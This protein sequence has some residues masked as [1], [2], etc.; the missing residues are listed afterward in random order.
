MDQIV[1]AVVDSTDEII[2]PRKISIHNLSEFWADYISFSLVSLFHVIDPYASQSVNFFSA[3]ERSVCKKQQHRNMFPSFA[4]TSV[5][6]FTMLQLFLR[7]RVLPCPWR[8]QLKPCF[9]MTDDS[10]LIVC[11]TDI[12]PPPNLILPLVPFLHASTVLPLRQHWLCN[13]HFTGRGAGTVGR[14]SVSQII[15]RQ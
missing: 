6:F 4:S 12:N 11:P 9:A 15:T 1:S 7:L 3:L 2:C 14:L 10:S 8:L 5:K 13:S